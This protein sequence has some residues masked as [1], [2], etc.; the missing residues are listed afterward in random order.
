MPTEGWWTKAWDETATA[1]P[2]KTQTAKG[3]PDNSGKPVLRFFSWSVRTGRTSDLPSRASA[4]VGQ[5]P[6]G[7]GTPF[8]R[9]AAIWEGRSLGH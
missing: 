1:F 6:R 5:P 4:A 3:T 2:R 8:V 9:F 7:S